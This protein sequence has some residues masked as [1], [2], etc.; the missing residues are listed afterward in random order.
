MT[1][2]TVHTGSNENYSQGWDT[3]FGKGEK[4]KKSSG[5]AAPKPAKKSVAK[6]A[7]SKSKKK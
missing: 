7:N 5:K 6:K 3:I 2:Y 4:G 1:G